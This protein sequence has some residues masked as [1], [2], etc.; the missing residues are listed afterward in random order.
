MLNK[1]FIIEYHIRKYFKQRVLNFLY[2]HK[3]QLNSIVAMC[4]GGQGKLNSSKAI[5]TYNNKI[6][7]WKQTKGCIIPWDI[8]S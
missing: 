3:L 2:L 6:M 7:S 5:V 4:I 8:G 1:N